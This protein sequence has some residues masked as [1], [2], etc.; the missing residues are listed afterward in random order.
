M[1]EVSCDLLER[2]SERA[3]KRTF[4]KLVPELVDWVV[5]AWYDEPP[6]SVDRG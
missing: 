3:L 6:T 2:S 1:R 5:T 4:N